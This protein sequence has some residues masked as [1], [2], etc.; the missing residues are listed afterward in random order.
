MPTRGSYVHGKSFGGIPEMLILFNFL[1][2]LMVSDK[3]IHMAIRT[4]TTL[5]INKTH[6]ENILISLFTKTVHWL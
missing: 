1:K 3:T 4:H 5:F 2:I 6:L